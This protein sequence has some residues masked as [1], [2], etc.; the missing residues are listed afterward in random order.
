MISNKK[1]RTIIEGLMRDIDERRHCQNR[2]AGTGELERNPNSGA[3][4]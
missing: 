2:S 1:A 4:S 3:I